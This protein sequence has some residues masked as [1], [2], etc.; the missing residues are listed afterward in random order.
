MQT[1]QS[2]T[3]TT[4]DANYSHQPKA[5]SIGYYRES[6]IVPR[7]Y[8]KHMYVTK[9]QNSDDHPLQKLTRHVVFKKSVSPTDQKTI[10]NYLKH[11]A[12]NKETIH[13]LRKKKYPIVLHDSE[14]HCALT[15]DKNL[16]GT[17]AH[18]YYLS[19]DKP[20][21]HSKQDTLNI[22][23]KTSQ[24]LKEDHTV[25]LDKTTGQLYTSGQQSIQHIRHEIKMLSAL[26]F[27][28]N[29][30]P[31][32]GFSYLGHLPENEQSIIDTYAIYPTYTS[33]A[34][35]F[36]FRSQ[37][38]HDIIH[39]VYQI[40]QGI[41][42][43]SNNNIVHQDIRLENCLIQAQGFN[44]VIS[45]FG[46]AIYLQ[47][48]QV[49]YQQLITGGNPDFLPPERLFNEHEINHT[50]DSIGWAFLIRNIFCLK[51]RMR[52][53][54]TAEDA[55]VYQFEPHYFKLVKTMLSFIESTEIPNVPSKQIEEKVIALRDNFKKED[56]NLQM[57]ACYKADK[58]PDSLHML[59]IILAPCLVSVMQKNVSDRASHESLLNYLKP[60]IS[61]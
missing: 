18:M 3:S 59:A 56:Y 42:F 19:S 1:T 40:M 21:S 50:L 57:L 24:C 7:G 29:I 54:A 15:M 39:F 37:K 48:N 5:S 38:T 61:H 14:N 47:K 33:D 4:L 46:T 25:K 58:N 43:L 32:L 34:H 60:M 53:D 9:I 11:L 8:E 35:V 17:F 36:F 49:I 10:I 12:E 45:D 30:I 20:I 6:V 16:E 28:P 13:D 52:L 2:E 41:L 44:C 23:F 51:K 26:A 55:M 27:H 22:A 31:L